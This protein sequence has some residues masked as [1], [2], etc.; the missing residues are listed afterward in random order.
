MRL[1]NFYFSSDNVSSICW[2]AN[3]SPLSI[4][5]WT[6]FIAQIVNWTKFNWSIPIVPK[7]LFEQIVNLA[8]FNWT[9][10]LNQ[11]VQL[12]APFINDKIGQFTTVE[13]TFVHGTFYSCWIGNFIFTIAL[14]WIT[15]QNDK[16]PV[17]CNEHPAGKG[18]GSLTTTLRREWCQGE[19]ETLLQGENT[20]RI[21]VC[22][23]VVLGYMDKKGNDFTTVYSK[24]CVYQ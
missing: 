12:T 9:G 5:N 1:W 17:G 24:R 15:S 22:L 23:F 10:E 7:E 13:W 21:W 11:F 3:K 14:E 8:K 16:Q 19:P 4:E 2:S 6:N 20:A 18:L